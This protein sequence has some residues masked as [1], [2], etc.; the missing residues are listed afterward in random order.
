[1]ELAGLER[2]FGSYP[3]RLYELARGIAISIP[4]SPIEYASRF[5]LKIPFRKTFRSRNATHP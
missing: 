3:Q 1:M 5:P 2:E 4:S